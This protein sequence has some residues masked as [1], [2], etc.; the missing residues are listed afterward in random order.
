MA[1]TYGSEVFAL[2]QHWMED[3]RGEFPA[4]HFDGLTQQLASL[5]QDELDNF[6]NPD[7]RDI[8]MKYYLTSRITEP[9]R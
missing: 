3:H 4:E 2:A 7:Y 6:T 5:L 9:L 8:T 1:T